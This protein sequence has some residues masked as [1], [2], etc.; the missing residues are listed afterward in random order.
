MRIVFMGTP[1]FA[2]PSLS[3]L[4]AEGHDVRA[5]VTVP[6]K[7]QGR[8]RKLG[9]SAVKDFAASRRIPLLQPENLS[10]AAFVESLADLEPE[11]FV[12]VAF[13]VLPAVVF[14]IPPKGAFNL[15]A[16]LLPKYR[17]AAPINWAI[18]KGEEET[19]VTTFLLEEKVDTGSIILQKCTP[20]GQDE[21]AGELA[22][23]L[24]QIGAQAVVE[25]VNLLGS[26]GATLTRQDHRLATPAPKIQKDLCAVNWSAPERDVHNFVRGLSPSPC[27]WTTFQGKNLRVY[28]TRRGDESELSTL[29]PGQPG[30]VVVVGKEKLLVRTGHGGAVS[31]AEI[32]QEGKKKMEIAEFLR[33]F[34]I[35]TGDFM[36][37]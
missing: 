3:A 35:R 9:T 10:D 5:V 21:T 4:L 14:S 12:V 6:D 27:A 34:A 36:G 16:S 23:R 7:P 24:A 2:I 26:G 25:T 17:G 22:G 15:H 11:L 18:M 29:G 28:R 19:G 37:Q 32:Q 31:V 1:S 33:G 13:R 8:G 30:E 20:I